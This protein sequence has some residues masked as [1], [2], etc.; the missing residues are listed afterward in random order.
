MQV[1]VG[2]KTIEQGELRVNVEATPLCSGSTL[3][4]RR[5]SDAAQS[6]TEQVSKH[7]KCQGAIGIKKLS[8]LLG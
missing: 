6:C 7:A 4:R 1:L 2:S 3:D 5:I 8:R